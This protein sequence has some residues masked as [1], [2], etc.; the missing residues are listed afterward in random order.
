MAK[1]KAAP[2]G[3][4]KEPEMNREPQSTDGRRRPPVH[5]KDPL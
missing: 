1:L 5:L 3:D 4:R 2:F